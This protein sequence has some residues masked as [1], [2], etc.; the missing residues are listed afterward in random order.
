[1]RVK[2][3]C[4]DHHRRLSKFEYMQ[5][6]KFIQTERIIKNPVTGTGAGV[7]RDV[8]KVSVSIRLPRRGGTS[9]SQVGFDSDFGIVFGFVY[10]YRIGKE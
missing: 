10:D 5:A 1:L 6:V 8:P 9:S 2:I 3:L 7:S 4:T